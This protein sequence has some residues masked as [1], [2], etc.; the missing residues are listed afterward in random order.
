MTRGA[1]PGARIDLRSDTVRRPCPAM[2]EA[3][4]TASVLRFCTHLDI[5]VADVED[6]VNRIARFR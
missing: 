1:D 2:R 6:A 3:A 5:D 4:A